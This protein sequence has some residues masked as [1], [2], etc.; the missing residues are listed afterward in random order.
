MVKSEKEQQTSSKSN[1][2]NVS[3]VSQLSFIDD[4][5]IIKTEDE[6]AFSS[7][8]VSKNQIKS[9]PSQISIANDAR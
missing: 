3:M 6:I 2:S 8:E 9:N 7:I 1:L 5:S 4:K